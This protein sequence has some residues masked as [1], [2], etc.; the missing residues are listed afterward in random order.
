[1]RNLAFIICDTF[2]IHLMIQCKANSFQKCQP[3]SWQDSSMN[4]YAWPQPSHTWVQSLGPTWWKKR[5]NSY[6]CPLT[7]IHEPWYVH[8]MSTCIHTIKCYEQNLNVNPYH[9]E[10]HIYHTRSQHWSAVLLSLASS[11]LR[12]SFLPDPLWYDYIIKSITGVY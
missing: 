6:N 8:H 10:K 4:R 7:S 9:Y 12:L 11:T 2:I 3:M 1:M 5:P